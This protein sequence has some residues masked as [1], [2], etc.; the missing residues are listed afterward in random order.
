MV[1]GA[2]I[3]VQTLRGRA[4]LLNATIAKDTFSGVNNKFP[5]EGNSWHRPVFINWLME[6]KNYTGI[7]L[8][9]YPCAVSF[10]V[11]STYTSKTATVIKAICGFWTVSKACTQERSKFVKPTLGVGWIEIAS[12]KQEHQ[13]L[14]WNGQDTVT[15]LRTA[16]S[17]WLFRTTHE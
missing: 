2:Q 6:T 12:E 17:H 8:P 9:V 16:Q 11:D 14:G 15:R 4:A 5:D 1:L 3:P 10:V 13:N 7:L